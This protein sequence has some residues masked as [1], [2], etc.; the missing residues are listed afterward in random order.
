M[1]VVKDATT[2]EEIKQSRKAYCRAMEQDKI[3]AY[4]A[5]TETWFRHWRDNQK[6]R[7]T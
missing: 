5:C 6:K 3:K 1:L 2:K 7:V 4:A